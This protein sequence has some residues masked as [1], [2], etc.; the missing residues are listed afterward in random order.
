[1]IYT[2]E[3]VSSLAQQHRLYSVPCSL[4]RSVDMTY[5]T[6]LAASRLYSDGAV[7]IDIVPVATVHAVLTR[8][9]TPRV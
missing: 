3:L 9:Y 8:I 2:M 5:S 7:D 6:V 1:M 4:I